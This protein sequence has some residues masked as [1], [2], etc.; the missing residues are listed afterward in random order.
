LEPHDSW[1]TKGTNSRLKVS[2]DCRALPAESPSTA[3]PVDLAGRLLAL[4]GCGDGGG[5]LRR[6]VEMLVETTESVQHPADPVER[7]VV[8]PLAGGSRRWRSAEFD[9]VDGAQTPRW[10]AAGPAR[11]LMTTEPIQSGDGRGAPA[12]A[13]PSEPV[14]GRG[15][16]HA[17]RGD[18][19]E[20]GGRAAAV[21]AGRR[22]PETGS[23]PASTVLLEL[24]T[25]TCPSPTAT[26]PSRTACR[27]RCRPRRAQML[28]YFIPRPDEKR[29]DRGGQPAGHRIKRVGFR[30]FAHQQL[31]QLPLGGVT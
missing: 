21:R 11:G 3:W 25:A 28:A 12:P 22:R 14:V 6:R 30:N 7:V 10:P 9:R 23:P 8:A 15:L 18:H 17:R 13:P 26:C 20:E 29:A 31:P 4:P 27:A 16:A 5:R 24:P 1:W 19:N 2:T